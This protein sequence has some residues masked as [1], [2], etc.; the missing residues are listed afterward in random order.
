M[1]K[2]K[3][4]SLLLAL[5]LLLA[6]FP[7]SA[8]ASSGYA[9]TG[10]GEDDIV[11]V[12]LSQ[13]GQTG[14]E[15][16]YA[17]EWCACFVTWAGRT[18][19]QD[20]PAED[21]YTP[22]DVARYFSV[23]DR[24]SFYCFRKRTYDSL[25]QGAPGLGAAVLTT[26]ANV[27]PKKGDLVCFLWPK[28]IEEGYNWSH[29]GILTQDYDGGGVLTTIEGNTGV[30]DTPQSRCVGIQSRPYNE[31]VVGII[32]PNY[33]SRSREVRHYLEQYGGG[34]TLAETE[35]VSPAG[36]EFTLEDALRSIRTYDTH[37][38]P[39]LEQLLA[40]IQAEG[41]LEL[42]Y[43]RLYTLVAVP[44]DG[45][46]Q[47]LGSGRYTAGTEVAVTV[48]A[49]PGSVLNWTDS[50]LRQKDGNVWTLVMPARD[51]LVGVSAK[52]P[53]CVEPFLDV[54]SG[55][56]YAKYV[57]GVYE[58]GLMKGTAADAFSPERGLTLAEA[59]ALAARLHSGA[60]GDGADFT[61][62]EG[63]PWYA[64][65]AAYAAENGLID[66]EGLD[67]QAAATRQ[68]FACILGRALPPEELEPLW[69]DPAFA[70][71]EEETPEEI[72]LLY[73]AGV[74]SGETA[75]GARYFRPGRTITRAEAAAV[76]AR[77]A[78]PA[79]R[80]KPE[81][82]AQPEPAETAEPAQPAEEP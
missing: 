59:A 77:M 58:L 70:D 64:P 76:V 67:L 49:A 27:A 16:G 45:V 18:A 11:S 66:E 38:Y 25:V 80:L 23:E 28:D 3:L 14:R 21:L 6:C 75:D 9:L 47:V 65:C 71:L 20:F 5:A 36:K 82:P 81:K 72:T 51:V 78:D 8:Q 39:N 56:W 12:A 33:S 52:K 2:K 10:Q 37:A 53:D 41:P 29:I 46:D 60:A 7:L 4:P 62:V 55:A 61:P 48:Q 69:E 24:G 35:A 40:S 34:Y 32:R 15:L 44:G 68:D 57:A 31:T 26:R 22:L 43:P 74:L 63:E 1:R 79:L 50:T 19:G 30:L 17:Y 13:L 73:R 54:A 42:Y